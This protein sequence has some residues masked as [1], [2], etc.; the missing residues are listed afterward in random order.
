[1]SDTSIPEPVASF[2]RS[3]ITSVWALELL[4][5]LKTHETSAWS[6]D[7]LVRELRGSRLL[8]ADL[9]LALHRSG[10]VEEVG[11]AYRYRPS[12][13]DVRSVVDQLERLSVE[14]PLAVRNAILAAPHD[15]VQVFADAFR[16]KKG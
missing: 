8:V 16:I 14:R 15:K 2:I 12:S 3:S 10:L 4:V 1:V 6:V 9:V 5:F 13:D 7:Q 11:E